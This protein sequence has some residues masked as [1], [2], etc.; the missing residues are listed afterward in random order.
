MSTGRP[1]EWR[2][3]SLV[4]TRH[5]AMRR[6]PGSVS[7]IR[8]TTSM[9][10]RD[11]GFGQCAAHFGAVSTA[12]SGVGRAERV[13]SAQGSDE[14]WELLNGW[15]SSE[16]RPVRR[17]CTPDCAACTV[18]C[19]LGR[20]NRRSGSQSPWL[21]PVAVEARMR[22]RQIV[23]PSEDRRDALVF[24]SRRTCDG[25][26]PRR[27]GARAAH[28]GGSAAARRN[29][30]TSGRHRARALLASSGPLGPV[31]GGDRSDSHGANVAGVPPGLHP[32]PPVPGCAGADGAADQRALSRE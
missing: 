10:R 16:N 32:L 7:E 24:P 11:L 9:R 15:K 3:A 26:R 14:S 31:A 23:V 29:P 5:E 22:A 13:H 2:P 30:P 4:R 21:P 25:Q 20:A 12:R 1:R 17:H 8:A 6:N 18:D 27:P 19:A 28:G